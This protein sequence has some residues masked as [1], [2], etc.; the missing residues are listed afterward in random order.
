MPY[1]LI[2]NT[3]PEERRVALI[4]GSTLHEL[5]LERRFERGLVGNI[6]KGKVVRVLPGMDVAFV[7]IGT[8]RAAFLQ[9]NDAI[10]PRDAIP[11]DMQVADESG[12]NEVS[13]KIPGLTDAAGEVAARGVSVGQDILVQVTRDAFGNKGPRLSLQVSLPGR[14]LVFLP[15][16]PILGVS[17]RIIDD[18]ERTRLK[19]IVSATLPPGAGAILRTAA[20]GRPDTEI[21]EDVGFLIALW[22]QILVLASEKD[23]P[24]LVHEDF[25][26]LFRVARDYLTE[27]CE[28]IVVDTLA[29][30]D[31]LLQFVDSFMPQLDHLVDRYD[32]SEP[33]FE[34][35][36]V[37]VTV[38]G[39]LDRV[40][41]LKSGGSIVIDHTEA[42]TAIDVNTA[43]FVG[44]G[45]PED[46]V[47]KT[48]LE[49]AREI[50]YQLRLR[51]IGGIVVIDF[52]DMN[53]PEHRRKVWDTLAEEL[54]KDKAYTE[55]LPMSR[56]GLVEMTRKRTRESGTSRMTE[57]CP[58]CDGRGL[59]RSVDQTCG[60]ILRK[61]GRD[62]SDVHT[63]ALRLVAHPRVIET[64]IENYR[65]SLADL[66]SR[67]QKPI[68]MV[69]RD[70]FHIEQFT[71]QRE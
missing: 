26:V 45:D 36:G 30:Y 8:G 12:D 5:F 49:A 28:Q 44:K 43:R 39:L 22:R 25:D 60:Q 68:R 35:Y 32:G 61:A 7:E 41:W 56:F 58:Y 34:H 53:D 50:A 29:E 62:L 66:E 52:I 65:T 70:D 51:N 20:E 69:R 63:R 38:A 55:V 17:R 13:V 4:E 6:Y 14:N 57:S 67:Y 48:N 23:A 21:A 24:S 1:R 54:R 33:I 64:L 19:A 15:N 18:A 46:T 31:R 42:M 59:V 11:E 27:E 16:T 10:L 3:T 71:L 2:V 47:F 40:L 9:C 37:E